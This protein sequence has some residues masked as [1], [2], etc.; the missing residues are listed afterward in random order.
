MDRDQTLPA[1]FQKLLDSLE[2]KERVNGKTVAIKM[3]LGG[4]LGYTTIHPLFV[5]LLVEHLK[6]AR[7]RKVFVTEGY[8]QDADR[9]GYT[10]ETLGAPI[11]QAF[12]KDGK[13]VCRKNT[14]WKPMKSVLLSRPILDADILVNFSH[15]KAHGDAGF[16]GACKNL[17]M[18]CVPTKTRGKIHSLE[19][20]LTWSRN[21][22]TLCRKCVKECAMNAASFN[23]RGEFQI[24]WHNCKMCL[25]CMLI[26]PTGA[27]RIEK[28][29]SDLMQEGL[30]R[31]AKAVI[32]SFKPEHVT[33]INILTNITLFCDCWGITTPSLVPDIGIFAGQDIV[34]VED[35]SLRSVKTKNLIP[36]SITPPFSL[37]KGAHL[38]EKLHAKDPFGQIRALEKLRTGSSSYR[39]VTIK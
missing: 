24:F 35:A 14:G 31:T 33:H 36:G 5:R 3:H 20:T 1:R 30:A 13:D 2:L 17:G 16:G 39:V 10:A 15:F 29:D 27:I 28:S 9:R 34:A 8:I 32:D 23:D 37:G 4:G 38:F 7:A 21:T 19:G 26:C 12:G 25:H 22:C 11:V 6:A 18:G